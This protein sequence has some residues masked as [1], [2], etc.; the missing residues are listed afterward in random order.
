M[1][2]NIFT[3]DEVDSS[4]ERKNKKYCYQSLNSEI[5]IVI[6]TSSG[7]NHIEALEI[8]KIIKRMVTDISKIGGIDNSIEIIDKMKFH[9]FDIMHA[10]DDIINPYN[11]KNEDNIM[12]LKQNGLMESQN[13]KDHN[14][15]LREK[16][17]KARENIVRGIEEIERLKGTGEYKDNSVSCRDMEAEEQSEGIISKAM[18]IQS[19]LIRG[20]NLKQRLLDR[21]EEN[22]RMEEQRMSK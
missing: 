12:K 1:S 9:A 8:L 21:L 19:K 22:R 15:I 2:K 13:E 5:Y 16:E 14:L 11:G 17:D 6:M 20:L 10:V 4:H 3:I 7:F 18:G